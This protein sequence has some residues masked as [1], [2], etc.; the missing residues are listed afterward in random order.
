[1]RRQYSGGWM[2]PRLRGG[3]ESYFGCFGFKEG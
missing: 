2:D 1:M 3:D